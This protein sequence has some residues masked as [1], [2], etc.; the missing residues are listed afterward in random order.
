MSDERSAEVAGIW[1]DTSL[2]PEEKQRRIAIAL[3]PSYTNSGRP[4]GEARLV[5]HH[6]AR[7]FRSYGETPSFPSTK[8]WPS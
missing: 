4:I 2:T 3:M 1:A 7:L 5:F 8:R 6:D